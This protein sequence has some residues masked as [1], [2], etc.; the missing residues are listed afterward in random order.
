MIEWTM[1]HKRRSIYKEEIK[2]DEKEIFCLSALIV[3]VVLII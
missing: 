3:H 1:R 2:E